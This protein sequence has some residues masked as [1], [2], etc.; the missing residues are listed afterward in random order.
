MQ[1]PLKTAHGWIDKTAHGWIDRISHEEGF[2]FIRAA[3]GRE[4]YFHRNA[5]P[6]GDFDRLDPGAGVTFCEVDGEKGPQASTV[7]LLGKTR[8]IVDLV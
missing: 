3:D 8:H 6:N 2:G 7:H 5:L 1:S 4:L